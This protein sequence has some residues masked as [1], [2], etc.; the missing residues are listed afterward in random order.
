[1]AVKH[2]LSTDMSGTIHLVSDITDAQ[3]VCGMY[4]GRAE[5]TVASS[6][7][8]LATLL[9]DTDSGCEKCATNAQGRARPRKKAPA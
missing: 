3:A 6:F 4:V 7:T 1:M 9:R 5:Y 2:L 8:S